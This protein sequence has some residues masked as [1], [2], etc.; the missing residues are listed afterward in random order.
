M[1]KKIKI[2]IILLFLCVFFYGNKMFAEENSIKNNLYQPDAITEEQL[3]VLAVASIEKTQNW[4]ANSF[5]LFLGNNLQNGSI[6]NATSQIRITRSIASYTK[7]YQVSIMD[8]EWA[9]VYGTTTIYRGALS[10]DIL[11]SAR[12]EMSRTYVLVVREM[13]PWGQLTGKNYPIGYFGTGVGQE[14]ASEK[15]KI[16]EITDKDR[17]ISGTATPNT[18]IYATV[19][20]DKYKG[21]VSSSGAY[22]INL[23]TTYPA[24]TGV[25]I[26]T[27]NNTGVKSESAIAIVKGSNDMIGVN[28][29]YS[30][31]SIITGKTIP[32][33]LVEASVDNSSER[34]RIY[35]GTSDSQGYFTI[36]MRGKTYPAGTQITLTAFKSDGTKISKLVIV[37]PRIPS[38]NTINISDT[39]IT[40]SADPNATIEVLINDTD[41][42]RTTVDAAGN[43]RVSVDPLKLGDKVSVYQESNGIMS[44]KVTI[45]VK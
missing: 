30:S 14:P 12:L 27:V 39:V 41:R 23:D 32:N 2:F 5:D 28:P 20:V 42:Y 24:G 31:D 34:A 13:D 16:N 11:L 1:W 33:V 9:K 36:D 43:F 19:G 10:G 38:V 45:I 44:D 3:S 40:G 35:D 37:Y 8:L 7:I 18:T 26:Y 4:A 22:V 25:E 29:I 17:T 15:P 6:T 21:T